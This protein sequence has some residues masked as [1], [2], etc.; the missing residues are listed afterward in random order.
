MAP[1]SLASK[2]PA[3]QAEIATHSLQARD[4]ASTVSVGLAA[5]ST[6]VAAQA[7]SKPAP[8]LGRVEIQERLGGGSFG[9]VFRAYGPRLD[10]LVAL[11]I[12]RSHRL[13]NPDDVERFFREA[14]AAAQF[15]HPHIVP[16]FEVGQEQG[17]PYIVCGLI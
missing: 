1:K 11:K 5:G 12:A 6:A 14:R 15:K 8:R 9:E 10:R 13:D 4:P 17:R 2:P 7:A 3:D 16:V